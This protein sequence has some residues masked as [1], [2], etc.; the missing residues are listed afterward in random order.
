[1]SSQFKQNSTCKF[2]FLNDESL[3]VDQ[4]LLE[5]NPS[6]ILSQLYNNSD[7]ND[8]QEIVIHVEKPKLQLRLLI[9]IL[10]DPN[11]DLSSLKVPV[12]SELYETYQNYYPDCDQKNI[13]IIMTCLLKTFVIDYEDDILPVRFE[14]NIDIFTQASLS[15]YLIRFFE[16][17]IKDGIYGIF[18]NNGINDEKLNILRE[19]HV[20]FNYM[21]I[22]FLI[23]TGEFSCEEDYSRMFYLEYPSIIKSLKTVVISRI[24]QDKNKNLAKGYGELSMNDMYLYNISNEQTV[25]IPNNNV[26]ISS[27]YHM[28]KL[29]MSRI[30]DPEWLHYIMNNNLDQYCSSVTYKYQSDDQINSFITLLA[31]IDM[32]HVTQ[33][34][35]INTSTLLKLKIL[36]HIITSQRFPLLEEITIPYNDIDIHSLLDWF[37]NNEF[38]QLKTIHLYPLTFDKEYIPLIEY[39]YIHNYRVTYNHIVFHGYDDIVLFNKYISLADYD[40]HCEFIT[41]MD[42]IDVQSSLPESFSF[43]KSLFQMFLPSMDSIV[44]HSCPC[45]TPTISTF[46]LSIQGHFQKLTSL[47]LIGSMTTTL[48]T[49]LILNNLQYF[50]KGS[51]PFVNTINIKYITLSVACFSLFLHRICVSYKKEDPRGDYPVVIT[52]N[53]LKILFRP[54]S[55]SAEEH[56]F[57]RRPSIVD[58]FTK[59]KKRSDSSMQHYFEDLVHPASVKLV[60]HS[61]N[62]GDDLFNAFFRWFQLCDENDFVSLSFIKCGLSMRSLQLILN[63]GIEH[64]QPKTCSLIIRDTSFGYGESDSFIE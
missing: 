57:K 56:N 45:N 2:V 44:V 1:M 42:S 16:K 4:S 11:Y 62:I 53:S 13:E 50:P 58:F 63:S 19:Y 60:F 18:I 15:F 10:E 41:M 29:I 40:P 25:S 5:M 39:L 17:Y 7:K 20:L 33:F 27:P 47:T 35:S 21:N 55:S 49:D 31:S 52:F 32:S 36:K 48:K 26:F 30:S 54:G 22:H 43:F 12:L 9:S 23:I 6:F 28:S 51:L 46:F 34:I 64:Y 59:F 14:K 37:N 3:I 8:D 38:P 61:C 24:P